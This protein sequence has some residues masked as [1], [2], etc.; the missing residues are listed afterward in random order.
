MSDNQPALRDGYTRIVNDV[1]KAWPKARLSAYEL[2][3]CIAIAQRT[4]GFNKGKDRIAACQ[5]AEDM[6]ITRPKASKILN[7]LLRMNVVIREG[8]AHGPIKINTTTAQWL[9][10]TKATRA[11]VVRETYPIKGQGDDMGTVYPNRVLNTYPIW[12]HTR[13]K[14]QS[15]SIAAQ[16]PSDSDESTLA[17]EPNNFSAAEP[18]FP[19]PHTKKPICPYRKIVDLYHQILPELPAVQ[20]LSEKRKK[21]IR[22]R[23]LSSVGTQT[24]THCST[25]DF[26]ERYFNYVRTKCPF[27]MGQ[28]QVSP[29]RTTFFADLEWLTNASNFI[30][31]IERRYENKKGE[32]ENDPSGKNTQSNRSELSRQQTDL[33]YA[34]DNF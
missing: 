14:R 18:E 3:M 33:E 32:P 6:G 12:G 15:N 17:V 20:V 23:W 26:W 21:Q 30:K 27:L 4:F 28:G 31:V 22:A 5:L 34:I 11:P 29:G 1:M 19:I 8:G 24:K 10:P 9:R 7:Q 13:D 2:A 25:L 16:Y